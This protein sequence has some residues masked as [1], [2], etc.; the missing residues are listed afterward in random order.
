MQILK[1]GE[2]LNV[3]K[4]NPNS[5]PINKDVNQIFS[6]PQSIVYQHIIPFSH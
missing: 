3:K 6:L 5:K 4:R 1:A 2:F